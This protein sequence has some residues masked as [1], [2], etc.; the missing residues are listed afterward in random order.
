MKQAEPME[1]QMEPRVTDGQCGPRDS[2]VGDVV[3]DA[4]KYEEMKVF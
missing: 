4:Q 3:V 2:A 1:P